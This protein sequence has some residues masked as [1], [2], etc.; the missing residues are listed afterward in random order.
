M[1]L[2]IHNM[3][4]EITDIHKAEIFVHC[5]Q[6]MKVFT[7]CIN[8]TFQTDHVYIQCMDTTMVIIME[9]RLHASWF[10]NYTVDVPTTVGIS[11]TILHKV[12][13]VRDKQHI[14]RWTTEQK[15]DHLSVFFESADSKLVFDKSF[16]I[17]L[18][19]ID[20]ELLHIP[21]DVEYSAE[22]TL[23]SITFSSLTN[24]LKQFGDILNLSC[25]E[26]EINME[27][28]SQEFGKMKTNIPIQDLDEYAINEGETV[29]SSY[30]LKMISNVCLFQK[31]GPQVFLGLSP[32]FPFKIQYRIC[33][34]STLVFYVAP[35]ID[36]T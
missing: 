21:D 24:Q 29:T 35:R 33:E 17:P 22:I 6:H 23:P 25:T 31:V 5:F 1:I 7:D 4:L 3:R 12:L 11:T 15:Q 16:E 36:D 8:I 30:T 10:D 28:E 2:G 34:G 27:A 18:M 9:L 13:N 20:T 14:I 19:E 26:E 32:S